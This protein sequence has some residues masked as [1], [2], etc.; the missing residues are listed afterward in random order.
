MI[1]THCHVYEEEMSNYKEIIEECNKNNISLI[2]NGVDINSSKYIINLS[3][4]YNNVYS[5]VGLNYDTI[6]RVTRDDLK[7]L[8]KLLKKED[9][10][11]IGEIGL[12]YYWTKENK[13]KRYEAIRKYLD[14]LE[15]IHKEA[16]TE[17]KMKLLKSLYYDK[18]VISKDVLWEKYKA[19]ATNRTDKERLKTAINNIILNQKE[20]LDK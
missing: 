7:E 20:S 6:D 11:A 10:K 13:D 19:K 18:Y 17:T 12:D 4:N 15:K 9:I 5:A 2:I 3:K 8:E 1:D 14:R 16:N